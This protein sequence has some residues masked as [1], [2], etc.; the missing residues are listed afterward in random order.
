MKMVKLGAS[1]QLEWWNGGIMEFWV[2][3][4]FWVNDKIKNG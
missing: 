4:K 1:P 3:G 2:N